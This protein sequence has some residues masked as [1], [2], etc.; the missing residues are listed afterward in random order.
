VFEKERTEQSDCKTAIA[1]VWYFQWACLYVNL[2]LGPLRVSQLECWFVTL[3]LQREGAH[4]SIH[5]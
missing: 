3:D 5:V 4:S 2:D 1:T